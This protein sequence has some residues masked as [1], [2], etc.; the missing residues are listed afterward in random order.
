VTNASWAKAEST[1]MPIHDWT[2][3]DVGIFHHFHQRRIGVITD[4]LNQRLLPRECYA[5]AEQQGAG[6]EPDVL[7]PPKASEPPEPDDVGS[8][9]PVTSRW[10]VILDLR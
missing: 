10:R 7:P 6:F 9:P 5:L 3:V 8:R 2:R 4:V 1:I